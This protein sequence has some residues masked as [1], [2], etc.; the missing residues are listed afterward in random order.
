MRDWSQFLR[1]ILPLLD[2]LLAILAFGLAY[3]LRYNVQFIRPVDEINSAP[4]VPYL[5]YA[6]L[7]A[8]WLIATPPGAGLYRVQR[9]RSWVE[10]VY[11]I[12]NSATNATV[13]IMALSFLLK[14]LV[15]SRLMII[16]AAVICAVLLSFLRLIY[17]MVQAMLRKRGQGVER[18]L[19]VGM[20]DVGRMV[21]RNIVSRP[22]L[23]YQAIG[24]L[25]DKIE[26]GNT[27][28][29]RI[30]GYGGLDQL[31]MVLDTQPIDLVIVALPWSAYPKT[32]QIISECEKRRVQAR[33]VPDFYH[34]NLSR[35]Y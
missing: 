31:A 7:Y 20:G 12:L 35:P 30:Y 4:F 33:V 1:R 11:I 8:A 24:Y 13:V 3:I 23:G 21:L 27:D 32:A 28:I 15:F 18:A 22:D 25:D 6:I 9:G 29:G 14:P 26:R 10:E 5:P 17:R 34:L 2:F 16:E 19:I